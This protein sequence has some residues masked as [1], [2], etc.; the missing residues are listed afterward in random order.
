MPPTKRQIDYV[1][2]NV[3][4]EAVDT[5]CWAALLNHFDIRT[6]AEVRRET[7]SGNRPIKGHVVVDMALFDAKVQV[8]EVT[9]AQLA[10][11]KVR[12]P[13]IS[14]IDDGEMHL[15]AYVAHQQD[16]WLLTTADRAAVKAAFTL[17][18]DGCLRSLEELSR[19]C[20]QKPP[21]QEWFTTKWL[22]KVKTDCLLDSI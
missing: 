15:L 18:L 4:I 12:S 21:L 14:A 3:V 16:A 6:I 10:A 22:S 19:A 7:Q 13:V 20:G 5:G 1:D 11:A 8:A 9:K 17:G 2:T